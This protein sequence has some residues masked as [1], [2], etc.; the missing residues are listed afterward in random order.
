MRELGE[1]KTARAPLGAWAE[2]IPRLLGHGSFQNHGSVHTVLKRGLKVDR[3]AKKSS[4][5][6]SSRLSIGNWNWREVCEVLHAASVTNY[7]YYCAACYA[8]YSHIYPCTVHHSHL[9]LSFT[10]NGAPF[11]FLQSQEQEGVLCKT[12]LFT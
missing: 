1:P 5:S 2:G 10:S 3:T 9:P 8:V 4:W 7:H 11:P 6:L 12:Y